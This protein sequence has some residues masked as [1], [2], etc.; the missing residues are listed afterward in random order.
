MLHRKDDLEPRDRFLWI[1]VS[2]LPSQLALQI[3][4]RSLRPVHCG[5]TQAKAP[6]A[7]DRRTRLMG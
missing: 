3:N 1:L 4:S 2:Q 5:R 7:Y 6:Q